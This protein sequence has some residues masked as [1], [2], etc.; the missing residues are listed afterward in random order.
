[1]NYARVVTEFRSRACAVNADTWGSMLELV[2]RWGRGEKFSEQEV[3]VRIRDANARN[4]VTREALDVYHQPVLISGRSRGG[5]SG[6]RGGSGGS[7]ALI[8]VLGVICNRANLV[9]DIS[10]GGGTSVEKL[11][12]QFRQAVSDPDVT[13]IVLDVDSSGGS[14][15]G[16]FELADE[17]YAAR[18]RK[19]IIAVANTLAASAAYAIAAAASEL[20]VAPSGQV[21]SIGVFAS[22]EDH[23]KELEREGVKITQ[24]SAGKYKTE[25]SSIEPLSDSARAELQ[26]KVDDFYRMFVRAVATCRGDTQA[27]V[28][29][30]YG[31]GRCATA[32]NALRANLADRVGTLD[33]E[34]ARLG[35]CRP[36]MG[37]ASAARGARVL[38]DFTGDR[39]AAAEESLP[40]SA[41]MTQ[42][43]RQFELEGGGYARKGAKRGTDP[44]EPDQDDDTPP[45]GCAC[46]ACRACSG[47]GK[48]E[49]DDDMA[50][51]CACSACQACAGYRAA[52]LTASA[53]TAGR[54]GGGEME[55]RRREIASW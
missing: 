22:H 30:G 1:M 45:C 34:L 29:A 3:E 50:C 9:S 23:S 8:P 39:A 25:G 21:G 11:T 4:G 51:S 46:N 2:A 52:T 7:V 31:Q 15:D 47:P 24:V 17:I 48:A 36:G 35:V 14:V 55:R 6:S 18:G 42:R 37:M 49:A 12:A 28:K 43:R 33:S 16:I 13:A 40:A 38:G 53:L 27:N 10:A 26:A 19:K 5:R 54:R 41:A 32:A 44:D 20:V